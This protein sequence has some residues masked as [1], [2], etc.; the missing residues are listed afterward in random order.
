[1]IWKL[2][3]EKLRRTG[4]MTTGKVVGSI[5]FATD[6]LLRVEKLTVSSSPH[7]I[8]NSGLKIYKNSTGNMLSGTSLAEESVES[9]ITTTNCL[10][11]W[12]LAIRLHIDMLMSASSQ[13]LEQIAPRTK[14]SNKIP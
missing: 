11:T 14:I 6:K 10:V 1:M 12:H 3:F 9:I 4:I 8:N 5:F 7:L 13:S 2:K